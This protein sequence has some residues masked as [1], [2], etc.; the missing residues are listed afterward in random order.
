MQQLHTPAAVNDGCAM[1]LDKFPVLRGHGSIA[2]WAVIKAVSKNDPSM[3]R[4]ARQ[5][6]PIIEYFY[7]A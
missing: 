6:D 7:C 3:H 5:L 2:L 1:Q 4:F